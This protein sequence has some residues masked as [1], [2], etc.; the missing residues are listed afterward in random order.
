MRRIEEEGKA[1]RLAILGGVKDNS[2]HFLLKSPEFSMA[3]DAS[4]ELNLMLLPQRKQLL[5]PLTSQLI[6]HLSKRIKQVCFS[7]YFKKFLFY[8][9]V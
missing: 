8:I 3:K 9:G 7:L 1:K 6:C 4:S 5:L 2:S